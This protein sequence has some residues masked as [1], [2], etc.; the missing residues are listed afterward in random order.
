MK[1][2]GIISVNNGDYIKLFGST[3]EPRKN[4]YKIHYHPTI[5]LCFCIKGSGIYKTKKTSYSIAE[6]DIFLFRPNE[7]HCITDISADSDMELI[8]FHISPKFLTIFQGSPLIR[9]FLLSTN[10]QTNKI[11]DLSHSPFFIEHLRVILKE[12]NEKKEGFEQIIKTL[13]S[14]IFFYI[15]RLLGQ[16]NQPLTKNFNVEIINTI[17]EEIDMHYKESITLEQIANK[18]HYNKNYLCTVFKKIFG[19]SIWTYITIKRIDAAS[20]LLKTT[21]LSITDVYLQCGF[22][23]S[24]NFNKY[25]KQ[26]TGKTPREYIA[27][28]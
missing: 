17:I 15:G 3:A 28:Q 25:F 9:P 12:F 19:T 22:N 8:N 11:S 5:E 4:A 10:I 21:K 7:L 13:L 20:E 14:T 18:L 24:A 26:Y 23:N 1:T 6:N 16:S 2:I 27:N